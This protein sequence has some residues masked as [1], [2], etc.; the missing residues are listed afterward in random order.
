M[1]PTCTIRDIRAAFAEK[2]EN[3]NI[4]AKDSES[5]SGSDTI[6]I[7][8]ASF[9]ADEE[10]I[11]GSPNMDYVKHELEWYRSQS[12][13]VNDIPVMTPQ[14]WKQVASPG[15]FINSNYGYLVHN[16][17][18]G[19]QYKNVLNTLAA[20][21]NSR[22]GNMIYTRPSIH[23]DWN[24]DG[25]SDFICTNNVQYLIRDNKLHAVVNMRSND[26]IFGFLNDYQWQ[27]CVQSD[28]ALDILAKTGLDLEL[29]TIHWQVASLHIYRRH[30][31]LVD[32]FVKTGEININL[33]DYNKRLA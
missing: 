29:G 25:M 30:F 31:Y 13:N 4:L 14:I 20:D 8:G 15:G 24:T 7:F 5:L 32:N 23:K 9:I 22:R 2:F 10:A 17:K 26:A 28:L 16:E 19:S 27:R 21:P 18:N 6:E 1:L 12:L 33:S 3:F 11:F